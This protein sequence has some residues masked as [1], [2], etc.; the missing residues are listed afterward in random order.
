MF[1]PFNI[2]NKKKVGI[3]LGSGGAKGISHI[4]VM[5]YIDELGIPVDILAGSSIGAV[6]A[7]LY[8]SGKMADFKSDLLRMK[9]KEMLALFDPVF[10]VSGL[11]E[12]EKI[13][14][15]LSKYI[16]PG[17]NIEDLSLPLAIVTTDYHTGMPIIFRRGN[18]LNALRASIS[19]PGVF[20]PVKYNDKLL[21]DGGVS[22]PLPIDVA[23]DMG[24]GITIAVNLHH[25]VYQKRMKKMMKNIISNSTT[26]KMKP[27]II[28]A[29]S[30]LLLRNIPIRKKTEKKQWFKSVEQWL[31]AVDSS[32]K[33]EKMPNIFEMITKT[34]E[35][36]G[37]IN[38]MLMLDY[39]RPNVLIQPKL[40]K[41]ASLDF[42]DSSMVL[43]EGRTACE[44]EKKTLSKIAGKF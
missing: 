25:A 34:F 2:F 21:I 7:A 1:N 36:M 23:R 15:F 12:G 27:H 31:G 10:P 40:L 44:L 28:S 30:K 3:V 17:L 26:E 39:Y 41:I 14:D 37:Y 43:N 18:V 6:V 24:A 29:K 19:I 16:P 11:I 8:A 42:T 4:S 5:E 35:I 9:W 13:I 38:T 32:K 20:I 33:D 22:K